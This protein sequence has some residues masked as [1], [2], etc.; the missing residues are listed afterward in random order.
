VSVNRSG[1]DGVCQVMRGQLD[2]LDAALRI[3]TMR[4]TRAQSDLTQAGQEAR[5]AIDSL[6]DVLHNLRP[7]LAGETADRA[8]AAAACADTLR[9]PFANDEAVQRWRDT[10][11]GPGWTPDWSTGWSTGHRRDHGA[12]R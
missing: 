12:D 5:A 4:D 8:Q 2:R 1:F 7:H 11:S 9:Q 10:G 6:L 3:W